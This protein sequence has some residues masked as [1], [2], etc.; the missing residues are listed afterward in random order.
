ML[1]GGY[2]LRESGLA[3]MGAFPRWEGIIFMSGL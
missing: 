2:F 1:K 3:G